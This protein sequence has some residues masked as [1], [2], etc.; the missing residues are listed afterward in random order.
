MN[1]ADI[2]KIRLTNQQI[3]GTKFSQPN[4]LVS[5]FGAVQAQDYAMAKWAIG[6]R[7]PGTT[8]QSIEDAIDDGSIV[9]THVMRPTWHFVSAE[10]IRWMLDLTAPR[11]IAACSFRKRWLELDDK[12]LV[13]SNKLIAKALEG[14]THLTRQELMTELERSG[15]KTGIERATHLMLQAELDGIVCNGKRRGKQ[16]TY[17]LLDERV[18]KTR[19]LTRDEALAKLAGR[20][21]ESHGPAT[22]QDFLWWSGLRGSDATA[23]LETVKGQMVSER[24]DGQ[25]YW[26]P[27]SVIEPSPTKKSVYLLP[28]FD[29]FTVSYK[30]RT[31]SVAP[32]LLKDVTVGHAIFK[33]IIVVD[34][35][36]VGIWKRTHTNNSI[37]VEYTF[38]ADLK[39]SERTLLD[40]VMRNYGAFEGKPLNLTNTA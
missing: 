34:G 22:R 14:G 13:R 11:I 26:M 23:A 21:F 28:A 20:Y 4:E 29:E 17:A 31:A 1:K 25:I 24:I 18:A 9:R 40:R 30:D 33:P 7:L 6:L 12:T 27:N 8:Q 16:F 37:V 39:K 32:E 3:A 2:A 19:P 35:R 38:F 36:V 5:W 15:I 10:D